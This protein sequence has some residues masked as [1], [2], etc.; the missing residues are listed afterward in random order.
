[1][2]RCACGRPVTPR[3]ACGCCCLEHDDVPHLPARRTTREILRTGDDH[4]R[5]LIARLR[6]A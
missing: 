6:S 2:A 5:D 3:S 4:G 1:M